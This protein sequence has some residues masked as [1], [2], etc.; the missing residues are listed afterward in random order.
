[1][2][3]RRNGRYEPISGQILI[4]DVPIEM[5]DVHYLRSRIVMVDQHTVLFNTSIRN[6]IAYGCDA[7]DEEVIQ[8]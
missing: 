3:T 5:Y 8:A 4:D 1:M 2:L 6:N 7:T